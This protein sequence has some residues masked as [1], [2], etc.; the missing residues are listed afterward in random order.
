MRG[1]AGPEKQ[2]RSRVLGTANQQPYMVNYV[3]GL[4]GAN[5]RLSLMIYY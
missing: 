5:M 2:P 4:V 1:F 3:L